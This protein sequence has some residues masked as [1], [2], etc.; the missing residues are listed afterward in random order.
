MHL[1]II[2]LVGVLTHM[3][4]NDNDEVKIPVSAL[5]DKVVWSLIVA[6]AGFAVRQVIMLNDNVQEMNKSVAVMLN[7]VQRLEDDNKEMKSDINNLKYNN[8][9]KRR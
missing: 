6:I 5:L 9:N 2:L 1:S 8:T 3:T 7:K 4:N